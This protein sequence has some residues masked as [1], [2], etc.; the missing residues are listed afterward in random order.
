MLETEIR[1]RPNTLT[2]PESNE[3]AITLDSG[4]AANEN[5]PDNHNPP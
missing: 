3:S 1:M 4:H 2:S 5:T